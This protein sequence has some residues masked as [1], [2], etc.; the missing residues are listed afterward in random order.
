VAYVGCLVL[1]SA[2]PVCA[3]LKHPR[4]LGDDALITLTFAKNL[5]A[6]HGFVL[7]HPP[8]VLGTT[9]PLTTLLAA[10]VHFLLPSVELPTIA[11]VLSCAAWLAIPWTLFVYR[12]AWHLESWQALI[13]GLFVLAP[14]WLATIGME[15]Y[16]FAL[17]LVWCCSLYHAG[18]MLSAGVV[19]GLLFLTRGEGA[20]AP[21]VLVLAQLLAAWRADKLRDRATFVV[22][23][24]LVAGFGLPV[25]LWAFYALPTFGALLPSTLAAKQAQAASGLWRTL[26]WRLWFEWMPHWGGPLALGGPAPFNLW[27]GLV[28]LGLWATLRQHQHLSTLVAWGWLYVLGY[29]LLGVAAQAWYQYPLLLVANLMAG[30]GLVQLLGWSARLRC[31]AAVRRSAAALLVAAC[32]IALAMPTA[33]WIRERRPPS[34]AESYHRLARWFH[35]NAPASASVAYIEI[36]Y[37]GFYSDNRIVDLAG[38]LER[39]TAEHVA[40]RDFAWAFW[41]ARPDYYVHVPEFDGLLGA[42]PRDPRFRQWYRPVARMPGKLKHE[43][44]IFR[45]IGRR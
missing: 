16:L 14:G 9:S 22:L 10:G 2:L 33:R 7:N 11:I 32:T 44:V 23:A 18:Q 36:G 45:R 24:R 41:R 19:A 15:T 38:L 5:A 13:L 8:A 31:P 21:L 43:L 1:A 26:P 28:A 37:L 6:G 35:D 3:A 20:L 30:I 40:R 27:W 34:Y 17:L 39:E 25:V 42:I 29:A 12:R 4:F